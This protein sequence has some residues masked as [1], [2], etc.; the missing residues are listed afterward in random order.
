MTL[1]DV[2]SLLGG[3]ALFLYGMSVMGNG[4]EKQS[5]GKLERILEKLTSTPVRGVL[6]GAAVTAVIQSS[7][8][9]TVMVVGF[10][11]AGIMKLRQAI[12]II[13]GANVGTTVT[14]WIL[15]LTSLEGDS[16]IVQ[17]CKPSS[18]SP[19]LAFAG[20]LLLLFC[21]SERKK[22]VGTILLGFAVLMFGMEMMSGA[23]EPL[24]EVPEFV[25]MLTLFENP[26]MGV[27]TGAVLTAVIQSSSAS[28]GILQALSAT[29]GITYAAA[30]PI[31]AGQNIGTC[32]TAL[33]SAVGASKGA[34]RAA[35]VH[36]YFNLIGT[37][38]LLSCYYIFSAIAQP[39]FVGQA[40]GAGGIALIHTGFNLLA[41]ALLLPFH[42]VLEKLAYRTV[43]E[44]AEEK[45]FA[46]LDERFLNTPSFA[47]EQCRNMTHTMSGLCRDTLFQSMDCVDRYDEAVGRRIQEAEEKVDHYEDQLGTYLVKI[48]GRSL[49]ENDSKEVSAL[50]HVIGDFE[51]ISDHA[52]NILRAAQ[53]LHQK[54][55][56]FSS[57][58]E[59]E[60]AVLS[61]AVREVLRLAVDAFQKWDVELAGRVEPL[62][63]VVDR[64]RQILQSRH[65]NRLRNGE[66]TI[67]MGFILSDLLHNYERVADHCSNI[68]VCIIEISRGSFDT[69]AYLD[70]VKHSEES[71][72]E[73]AYEAYKEKYA[74]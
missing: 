28:V 36:L 7:S 18:F 45:E 48:S 40:I 74:L 44:G 16:L 32:A 14:A 54:N 20:V 46:L 60:L 47:I 15:S 17:L 66:C 25:S 29:G 63:Q 11:N 56:R 41:T 21:K 65:V 37:V 4:L 64:L 6:L 27:L 71:E 5:G 57:T 58:A 31:I 30:I 38:V 72:F 8:A 73:A 50:L 42:R 55:L 67:E 13:M 62:E 24:R 19:I 51:R 12:G 43:R 34:K 53:E 10:V 52:V 2:L 22:D 68:A 59:R 1:F 23:V 35:V 9:T 70:T 33:L 39:A 49:S 3:L 69:H 61:S 26:L